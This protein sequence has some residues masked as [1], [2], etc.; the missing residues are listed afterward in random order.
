MGFWQKMSIRKQFLLLGILFFSMLAV[1]LIITNFYMTRQ[2]ELIFRDYI[3]NT[4]T[5]M[6]TR[7]SGYADQLNRFIISLAYDPAVQDFMASKNSLERFTNRQLLTRRLNQVSNI[8]EGIICFVVKPLNGN[9]AINERQLTFADISTLPEPLSNKAMFTGINTYHK[10]LGVS[11]TFHCYMVALKSFSVRQNAPTNTN[12]GTVFMLLDGNKLGKNLGIG[13]KQDETSYY[14]LDNNQRIVYSTVTVSGS[15]FE[16]FDLKVCPEGEVQSIYIKNVKHFVYKEYNVVMGMYVLSITPSSS[17]LN[18]IGKI[19]VTEL[20]I[21]I[22]LAIITVFIFYFF[23]RSAVRPLWIMA[24][25]VDKITI[26]QGK[27]ETK[28]VLHGNRE[29]ELL[30]QDFNLMLDTMDKLNSRLVEAEVY[31]K[32]S[33]IAMLSSQIN[34]HFLY[35]TLETIKGMA[36]AIGNQDIAKTISALGR[37]FR[38][39][40]KAPEFVTLKSEVDMLNDYLSIQQ[41]RFAG[42]FEVTMNIE[43]DTLDCTLPKML[44]QP[45]V[46][47]AIQHGLEVMKSNGQLRIRSRIEE[48][49]LRITI[50]DNGAGIEPMAL[51]QLQMEMEQQNAVSQGKGGNIK[52]G[53]VNVHGRIRRYYG[54]KYSLEI[55]S[56]Q[57]Q[58]V[59]A[60]YHLP[61]GRA[62]DV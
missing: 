3:T 13:S 59:T 11:D 58:G 52:I 60:V 40:V 16:L 32:Q 45:L 5:Q 38:Y 8:T 18:S 50:S 20:I 26:S 42:R 2:T 44:L 7:L 37:V 49:E 41:T 4:V 36:Y 34:P 12:L 53:V 48:G 23:Q 19:I 21:F 51:E 17:V 43:E 1:L 25:Y 61:V 9:P 24:N 62:S 57:G 28:L 46:E 35:N 22:A 29:A 31:K 6:N 15:A 27:R 10:M 55:I 33:E 30:A 39:S 56:L 14:V 47:N 54:E